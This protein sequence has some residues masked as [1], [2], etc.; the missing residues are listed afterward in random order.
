MDASLRFRLIRVARKKISSRDPSHDFG[1]AVR[2]LANAERIAEE[3]GGDLEV[4]VPSALFHD[5]VNYPKNHPL[6]HS[7]QQMAADAAEKMLKS[8]KNYPKGKIARVKT[9]IRECSFTNRTSPSTL[10]SKILQDA[11]ALES[12][13]A[14]AVMRTFASAGGLEKPFYDLSD[15]FSRNRKPD[16]GKYA[17]DL[18]YDRLLKVGLIMNTKTAKRMALKRE[19]FLRRFLRELENEASLRVGSAGEV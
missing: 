18:F 16:S 19:K 9:C 4:L 12:T 15:P 7:S 8:V 14:V 13:G 17:V 6:R 1:H 5:A 2:T 10:E 11:D 3:E